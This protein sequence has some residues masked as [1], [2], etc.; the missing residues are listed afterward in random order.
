[1]K[2]KPVKNQHGKH[3]Y[4]GKTLVCGWPELHKPVAR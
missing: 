2:P 1:M 3:C 4:E